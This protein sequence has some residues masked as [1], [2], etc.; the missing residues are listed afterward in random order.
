[1]TYIDIQGYNIYNIIIVKFIYMMILNAI[2]V[3]AIYV[4]NMNIK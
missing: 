1:M 2:Y 4:K 3:A